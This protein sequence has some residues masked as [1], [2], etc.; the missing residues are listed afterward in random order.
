VSPGPVIQ[1]LVRSGLGRQWKQ[2]PK[3][4]GA[5]ALTGEAYC[6]AHLGALYR[7]ILDFSQWRQGQ[8]CKGSRGAGAANCSAVLLLDHSEMPAVI[9]ER[10]FPHFGIKLK[11]T[12]REALEDVAG[13][14]A[15]QGS[16]Y[17]PD[18]GHKRAQASP[19]A[20]AWSRLF[21]EPGYKAVRS[22]ASAQSDEAPAA[23]A[24]ATA[25]TVAQ[26][27]VAIAAAAAVAAAA[28]I[29]GQGQ[30]LGD[31]NM[32]EEDEKGCDAERFHKKAGDAIG[33]SGDGSKVTD[34][35]V[36]DVGLGQRLISGAASDECAVDRVSI[37]EGQEFVIFAELGMARY[38]KGEWAQAGACWQYQLCWLTVV[39]LLAADGI[40]R[41]AAAVC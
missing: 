29:H 11:P 24:A 6:A 41:G 27:D 40:G 17:R 4:L 18:S 39:G 25:P 26:D 10:L 34:A 13:T 38:S 16:V 35:V 23:A 2:L 19:A 12:E 32:E 3:G 37:V 1:G 20:I 36:P 33:D 8:R 28:A 31:T 5:M 7:M 9:F 15:K 30:P 22:A 21:A 14:N